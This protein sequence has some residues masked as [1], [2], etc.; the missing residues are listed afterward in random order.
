MSDFRTIAIITETLRATLDQSVKKDYNPTRNPKAT[1][2]Q[3]VKQGGGKPDALPE[4]GVNVH[5]YHISPN[6]SW[7]N[8][9]LPTRTSSGETVQRPRLALDLH[10]LLT[11]YGED[12]LLEPQLILGSVTRTLHSH[13][14]LTSEQ[15]TQAISHAS[16]HLH[17]ELKQ[18]NPCPADE[19][20]RVKFTMIPLSLEE[21]SKLWSVFFQSYYTLSVVYQASVVF[22]DALETPSTPV[23]VKKRD[24]Y[25]K[26]NIER[27]VKLVTINADKRVIRVGDNIE[28]SGTNVGPG[29]VYLYVSEKL[30]PTKRSKLNPPYT[31]TVSG[32]SDTFEKVEVQ[33]D[34]TWDV[35]WDTSKRNSGGYVIHAV[36]KPRTAE[37]LSETE[38]AAVQVWLEN[39]AT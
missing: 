35:T 5:L 27:A 1:A 28:L 26:P 4:V 2:V 15:I 10:Y 8:E 17:D 39:D 24:L 7:R 20:E 25:V 19:I 16:E 33:A 34:L 29:Y 38:R 13:P 11:F 14:F 36:A 30:D 37:E 12:S 31:K 9:D 6:P 18:C 22:I 32:N 21:L 3:P 23:S